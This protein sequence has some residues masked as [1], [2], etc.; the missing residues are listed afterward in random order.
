[1][2]GWLFKMKIGVSRGNSRMSKTWNYEEMELEDFIKENS[3]TTRTA[4][5]T[6]Q[7]RNLPKKEQDNI[8]DIGG[9]VLGELKDGKR[10]RENLLNRSGLCL[11]ID[12][13]KAGLIEDIEARFSY[14]MYF[15]TTHKHLREKPRY[16][17]II[18]LSRRV[19]PDE[20][21]AIG[22][23]VASEI[24]I[25]MFD[26]TTY[27]PSRLMYWPS[28]SIDGEFIFRE[29]GSEF[30]NPDKVLAKYEDWKDTK[31]WPVSS[32]QGVIRDNLLKEQA[33]PLEK[34]GLIGGFCRTYT[35]DE[36][37]EVFLPHIYEKSEIEGRYDY[38]A[39]TSLAGVVVYSNKFAY[40]HHEIGRA[41]V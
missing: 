21:T 17:L 8:K 38:K 19:L 39:A 15:Y 2:R 36:A 9:F 29:I 37:M 4:E 31:S 18:P 20:Y 3:K 30:L 27:D 24:G 40:S 33:D 5:T 32:R 7:Y 25:E 13:A 23:M 16:R 6:S 26:D 41:H 34:E 35:V 14:K 11:D 10:K 12:Y 1:M 22:R 28:T